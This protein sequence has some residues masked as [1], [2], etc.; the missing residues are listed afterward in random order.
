[1]NLPGV[2]A[3]LTLNVSGV[4]TGPSSAFVDSAAVA[5]N[6]LKMTGKEA[7]YV[8]SVTVAA[9]SAQGQDL[10][11]APITASVTIVRNS[12]LF[13]LTA[14]RGIVAVIKRAVLRLPF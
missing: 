6:N 13:S 10:V 2:F 9:P 4:L 12:P 7:N 11:P 3:T 14:A 5:L 1:M 8:L